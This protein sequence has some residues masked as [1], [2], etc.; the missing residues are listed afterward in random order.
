MFL[1][2]SASILLFHF[3][4]YTVVANSDVWRECLYNVY[5]NATHGLIKPSKYEVCGTI[6][7]GKKI[8]QKRKLYE[9]ILMI[10]NY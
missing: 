3:S 4:Q 1:L 5:F 10:K 8:W 6:Q 9:F 2:L 7:P